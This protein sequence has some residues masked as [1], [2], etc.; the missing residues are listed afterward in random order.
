MTCAD[1]MLAQG[2]ERINGEQYNFNEFN[3]NFE[4]FYRDEDSAENRK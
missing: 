3:R 1:P 2:M 4:H